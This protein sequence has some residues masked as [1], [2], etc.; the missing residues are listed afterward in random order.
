MIDGIVTEEGVP[1][2]DVEVGGQDWQA[3][4]DTGFTPRVG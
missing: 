3:I 1:A 2:I 4:I